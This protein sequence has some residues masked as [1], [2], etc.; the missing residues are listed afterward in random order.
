MHIRLQESN[1]KL[2]SAIAKQ[3]PTP[4]SSNPSPL[5]TSDPTRSE[6]RVRVRA[7]YRV[8]DAVGV[9]TFRRSRC[10]EEPSATGNE[11]RMTDLPILPL[12][13]VLHVS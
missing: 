2:P 3:P 12:H 4:Y 6:A 13:C 7:E 11:V 1:P 10:Y 8:Q 9:C 5:Y